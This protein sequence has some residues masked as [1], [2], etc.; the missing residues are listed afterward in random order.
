M[1]GIDWKGSLVAILQAQIPKLAIVENV[2]PLGRNST[3]CRDHCIQ[4]RPS[5]TILPQM[6][7]ACLAS[8]YFGQ[9]NSDDPTNAY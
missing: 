2:L 8:L 6:V 7:G 5:S 9:Q 3:L 1:I 4:G